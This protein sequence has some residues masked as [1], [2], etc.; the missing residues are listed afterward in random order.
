MAELM[1]FNETD[2]ET[3]EHLVFEFAHASY[4]NEFDDGY[5]PNEDPDFEDPTGLDAFEYDTLKMIT[6][7]GDDIDEEFLHHIDFELVDDAFDDTR[8]CFRGRERHEHSLGQCDH[9]CCKIWH[10]EPLHPSKPVIFSKNTCKSIRALNTLANHMIGCTDKE[11]KNPNATGILIKA[12]LLARASRIFN[13]HTTAK[14]K[15][16]AN[17]SKLRIQ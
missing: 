15:S 16:I 7:N 10:L 17:A 12:S 13:S 9:I 11:C 1:N 4:L 2:G 5:D 3:G 8:V 6:S 14:L